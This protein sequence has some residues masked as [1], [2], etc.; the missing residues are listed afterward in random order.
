MGSSGDSVQEAVILV[1][2]LA[3]TVRLAGGWDGTEI[4]KTKLIES[5]LCK[6]LSMSENEKK[7]TNNLTPHLETTNSFFLDRVPH[8]FC[9]IRD[10]SH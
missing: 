10:I 3:A 7:N 5:V 6:Q 4:N 1:E 9:V 8:L 2:V